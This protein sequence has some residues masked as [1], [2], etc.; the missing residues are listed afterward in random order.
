MTQ[1]Y[2]RRVD[3]NPGSYDS[4]GPKM[5]VQGR[6]RLRGRG[7]GTAGP[8]AARAKAAGHA[9]RS[10]I[11][12]P[13]AAARTIRAKQPLEKTDASPRRGGP[14]GRGETEPGTRRTGWP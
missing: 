13:H 3:A 11:L 6:R 12:I 1:W 14:Q 5:I 7:N 9:C 2:R 4:P 10:R 8:A